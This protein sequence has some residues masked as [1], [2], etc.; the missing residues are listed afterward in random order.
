M[1]YAH[2]AAQRPLLG[3]RVGDVEVLEGVSADRYRDAAGNLE[4]PLQELV[5]A[6]VGRVELVAVLEQDAEAALR[7]ARLQHARAVRE[8]VEAALPEQLAYR[9]DGMRPRAEP[10]QAEAA[11]EVLALQEADFGIEAVPDGQPL[12]LDAVAVAVVVEL[13]AIADVVLAALGRAGLRPVGVDG[14]VVEEGERAVE[15]VGLIRGPAVPRHG[16]P[17]EDAADAAAPQNVPLDADHREVRGRRGGGRRVAGLHVQ[18]ADGELA[19]AA[20]HA[21]PGV[22]RHLDRRAR[23]H[24]PASPMR[25][26]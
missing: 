8:V 16:P 20:G 5:A 6:R 24:P 18:R 26:L 25:R 7:D 21:P 1:L 9:S 4:R 2:R 11:V 10:D 12:Q 17:G 3:Q 15:P 22:D 13:G 19:D 23:I 14:Q